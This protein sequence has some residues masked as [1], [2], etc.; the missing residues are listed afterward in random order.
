MSFTPFRQIRRS[1]SLTGNTVAPRRPTSWKVT[2][3]SR[4]LIQQNLTLRNLWDNHTIFSNTVSGWFVST[5]SL[6][7]CLTVQQ[8]HVVLLILQQPFPT[9]LGL[10]PSDSRPSCWGAR[11]SAGHPH[12]GLG[13]LQTDQGGEQWDRSWRHRSFCMVPFHTKWEMSRQLGTKNH[14]LLR[15][16]FSTS[17][18]IETDPSAKWKQTSA[19]PS[20]GLRFKFKLMA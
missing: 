18:G 3:C 8:L 15:S 10:A 14:F 19:R 11:W 1:P 2:T 4:F 5:T 13:Q 9:Q 6:L 16:L 17:W 12:W 7:C 20:S